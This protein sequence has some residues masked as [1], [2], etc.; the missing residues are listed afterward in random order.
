MFEGL[1]MFEFEDKRENI[2]VI[3]APSLEFKKISFKLVSAPSTS[4]HSR[5]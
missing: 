4:Q 3:A 1:S 5:G 2:T